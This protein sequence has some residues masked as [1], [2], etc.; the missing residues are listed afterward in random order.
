M[1]TASTKLS[2]ILPE[3]TD[4]TVVRTDYVTNLETIDAGVQLLDAGLT[5][6]A[7]LTTSANKMIYT[8]AS[9]VYATTTLSAFGIT[10]I[11]D[12]NAAAGRATLSAAA[13]GANSDI[14]ALTG[15]TTPLG[16]AYGGTGIANNAASTLTITGAYATTITV[17]NTTAV[18]LPT[19]GTLVN[20]AVATL[21]SLTSV[22][23]ITTGG[24]GTGA[25]VA[26]VTMTLG[27]DAAYD[28]YYRGASVLTRLAPNTAASNKFL[29]MIGTGSAGQAPSWEALGSADIPD[30]SSTYAVVAQTFYIGTTQVA[31]NRASAALTLAGITLTTPDIG[32]AT[33][34]SINKVAITAPTTSA[35][36]TLVTGS[37]LITAGAYAITLT[38][39]AATGV[40][41]P[42]SGTLYGTLADSI[43]SANLLSSMS[44]ET[45]T[46]VLVFGTSPT[47][48][49]Q[50]TTPKVTNSSALTIESTA[51]GVNI[52]THT[53]ATDDFT[54]NTTMFVVSGDTGFTGLGTAAP[55]YP[56]T[57]E[58]VGSALSGTLYGLTDF[59]CPAGT[60]ADQPG[61]ILGY[62]TAGAAIIMART[63]AAGQPLAFWTY[64]GAAW[65][66]GM[67][68]SKVGNVGIG[69]TTPTAVLHL[70][71]GTATASTAPLKFTAGTLLTTPELG[72]FEYVDAGAD[73]ILYFTLNVGSSVTRVQ[74]YPIP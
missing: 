2:L 61:I 15:L 46:G 18:T 55:A 3:A 63:N 28:V 33:A 27:S 42:T 22:G 48:T 8:T 41:L 51:A 45:G 38:S 6:I 59:R 56:F 21:S 57:L 14:T 5:S 11:D 72:T 69:E 54:V 66:E 60:V 43:S 36:L 25:V 10:L 34:T 53:D 44:D 64:T 65:S 49:T 37:S 47:F 32:V 70:K 31:I 29:R 30:I 71:A 74:I 24:L 67:R 73:G 19:S 26:G 7:A 12:A 50:I 35:T 16:A 39:T 62:D 23:T 9:D 68:I 13:L 20:T 1:A 17:T 52:N 4:A 58:M 40:T